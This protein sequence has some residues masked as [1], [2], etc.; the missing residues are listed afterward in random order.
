MYIFLQKK[1]RF[2]KYTYCTC[3]YLTN[4]TCKRYNTKVAKNCVVGV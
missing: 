1:R 3:L 2:T 4:F